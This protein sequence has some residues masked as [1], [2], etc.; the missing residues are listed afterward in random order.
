VHPARKKGLEHALNI[1]AIANQRLGQREWLV[2]DYSIADIHLFRLFWRFAASLKPDRA[3]LPHLFAH[4][5]RMLER[6]AVRRTL[7]VE[8]AVGYELPA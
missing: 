3:S 1:Y 7:E 2:G 5:D 8:Q 6:P 4:H